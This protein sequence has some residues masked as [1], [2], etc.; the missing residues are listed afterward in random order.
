VDEKGVVGMHDSRDTLRLNWL[1]ETMRLAGDDFGACDWNGT[2][3]KM[4]LDRFKEWRREPGA[5]ALD[6]MRKAIDTQVVHDTASNVGC[7]GKDPKTCPHLQKCD[8]AGGCIHGRGVEPVVALPPNG[9]A[10]GVAEARRVVAMQSAKESH[11]RMNEY[12]SGIEAGIETALSAIDNLIALESPPKMDV[13]TAKQRLGACLA[14]KHFFSSN[15]PYECLYCLTRG[16]ALSS[17]PPKVGDQD[18]TARRDFEREIYKRC[19]REDNAP[20]G[21]RP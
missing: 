6:A 14:G 21:H 17:V 2:L 5:N 15:E 9:F 13:P 11:V 19:D 4:V 3:L 1:A 18:D 20:E 10:A 16:D 8:D 7:D 12:A